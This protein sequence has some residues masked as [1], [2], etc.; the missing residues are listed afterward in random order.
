MSESKHAGA[1]TAMTKARS[2]GPIADVVRRAG[3]SLERVFK[4]ADVPLRLAYEPERT[5]L[6]KDQLRIVDGAS[7][8]LDD[9]VLALRLSTQGGLAGL[10]AFGSAVLSA[11]TLGDAIVAA[12][13]SISTGLQAGTAMTLTLTGPWAHW[14]YQ[15]TTP[16]D[17]GRNSNELLAYGYMLDLLRRYAGPDWAPHYVQSRDASEAQRRVAQALLNCD[18][19]RG[20]LASVVFP[21]ALLARTRTQ[22]GV[23]TWPQ[24]APV[25]GEDDMVACIT[26][27]VDLAVLEGTATIDWVSRHIGLSA[28]SLQRHLSAHG[29]AFRS[30]LNTV[31]RRRA[32]QRL[33]E[34]GRVTDVAFELGYSDAAHFSRAFRALAGVSPRQFQRNC[35]SQDAR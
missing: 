29:V 23:A 17:V 14:S 1:S 27:V 10:G 13:R 18:L 25:P 12:N 32:E 2:M 16:V 21:A 28:R 8:E 4:R 19:V 31:I 34:G 15:V 20:E 5:L 6:L 11:P 33:A 24:V 7:R 30:V 22:R 26:Q 3:G 9:P 35:L